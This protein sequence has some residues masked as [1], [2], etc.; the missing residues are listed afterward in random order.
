MKP[1]ERQELMRIIELEHKILYVPQI[2]RVE[3]SSF[4]K[5][6]YFVDFD[7][8]NE[9]KSQGKFRFINNNNGDWQLYNEELKKAKETDPNAIGNK[10]HSEVIDIADITNISVENYK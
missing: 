3:T 8:A 2:S 9:L 1:M 5:T 10:K 7:D 6:G 4:I